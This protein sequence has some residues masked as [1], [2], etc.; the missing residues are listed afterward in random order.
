MYNIDKDIPQPPDHQEVKD[1]L[2]T[3]D[4]GDSFLCDHD[5]YSVIANNAHLLGM[6]VKRRKVDCFQF[7]I[8][9]VA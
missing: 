4:I 1:F 2:K 7:R 8:W 9:R 3:L 5:D 6:R